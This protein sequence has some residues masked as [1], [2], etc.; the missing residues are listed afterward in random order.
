ML[1][2][3]QCSSIAMTSRI[4]LQDDDA[5]LRAALIVSIILGLTIARH[6]LKQL[7]A[8]PQPMGARP[9]ASGAGRRLDGPDRPDCRYSKEG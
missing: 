2:L 8:E 7:P 5:D 4:V 3:F 1:T 9:P 6:F